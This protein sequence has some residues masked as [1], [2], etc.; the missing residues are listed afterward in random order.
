MYTDIY[1]NFIGHSQE[2]ETN[3]RGE[4][5]NKLWHMHSRSTTH[6]K[7]GHTMGTTAAWMILGWCRK[8]VSKSYVLHDSIHL[9]LLKGQNYRN[10]EHINGC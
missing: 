5:L 3:E 6:S 9:T 10:G 8:P 7:K 2:L 1:N 4:W